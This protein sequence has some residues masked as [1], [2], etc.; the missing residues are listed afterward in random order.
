MHIDSGVDVA[1]AVQGIKTDNVAAVQMWGR[2]N[3][4]I[5]LFAIDSSNLSR[6]S[7]ASDNHLTV[8][9]SKYLAAILE[10]MNQRRVRKKIQLLDDV[11]GGVGCSI[12]GTSKSLHW[13]N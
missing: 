1:G 13:R 4:L 6:L 5:F 7:L 12:C 9:I 8:V 10:K 2:E 3:E 11:A